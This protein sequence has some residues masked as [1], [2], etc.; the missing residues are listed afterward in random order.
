M[1]YEAKG[2][3]E[4]ASAGIQPRRIAVVGS[5]NV[6]FVVPVPTLPAPGETTLGGDHLR[7]AGGKG[8]NQAVAAARLG[9]Q[10]DLVGRVGDDDLGRWLLHEIRK[11]GVDVEGVLPT[12][13]VPT[14][15]ALIVVDEAGQNAIAVSPGANGRLS[16]GD[17]AAAR[18]RLVGADV[19]MAQL[20]VP[21]DTVE[22]ALGVA[23]GTVLLN[24]AP[25]RPLSSTVLDRVDVLVPNRHELASLLGAPVPRSL[26]DV[27][28]L[29][30][31]LP[32]TCDVVVTL[33][34]QGSLVMSQGD[35][36]HVP[37]TTVE[38]VDTTGAGDAFCGGLAD[39]LVKGADLLAAARWASR[40]AGVSTSRWGAQASLPTREEVSR[41]PKRRS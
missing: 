15:V 3:E 22:A 36:E 14:G 9:Q 12:T 8:A 29:T 6:D 28:R 31:R 7:L 16:S 26:K 21:L 4:M 20:E 40:V 5:L 19:V 35:A 41:V 24:P 33:G 39:A 27:E 32:A 38:T 23:T 34:E 25:A 17:V 13:D 10:V 2:D 1:S 30:R 37:V 18:D 11:A